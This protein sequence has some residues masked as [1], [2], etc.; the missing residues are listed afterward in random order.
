MRAAFLVVLIDPEN[1]GENCADV[2]L[3]V[4]GAGS[5]ADAEPMRNGLATDRTTG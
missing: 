2:K 5:A 3:T 1:P 4:E